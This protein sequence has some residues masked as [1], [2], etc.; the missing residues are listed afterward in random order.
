MIW[1]R[2]NIVM[3]TRL[4]IVFIVS[5][6]L[7]FFFIGAEVSEIVAASHEA[8]PHV[9]A[10]A[11]AFFTSPV[12]FAR[13]SE[14]TRARID[15]ELA[16]DREAIAAGVCAARQQRHKALELMNAK[17]FAPADLSAALAMSRQTIAETAQRGH[18][19][20]IRTLSD[21]SPEERA[22][23]LETI[24]AQSPHRKLDC[25]SQSSAAAARATDTREQAH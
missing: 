16:G 13:L 8:H 14:G 20:F 10:A 9:A 11:S 23:V 22:V 6:A 19:A 24:K 18:A 1:T 3:S 7:N 25:P 4:R 15:K 2:K 21:L 5:L 17:P 12:F